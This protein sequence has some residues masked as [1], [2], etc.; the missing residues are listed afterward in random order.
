VRHLISRFFGHLSSRPLSPHEQT[1]VASR[2]GPDLT[3]L[4]FRQPYQDQRHAL[5]VASRV[6]DHL[7]EAALLHDVGKSMSR[8]GAIP[9]SLATVADLLRLPMPA[10]WRSY[11]RHGEIGSEMLQIAGAEPLTVAFA[12]YH[13]GPVPAGVAPDSWWALARAD[14][15]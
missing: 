7:C 14:E 12:R 8:L 13:P 15:S 11:L 2:L 9:R 10:R 6:D 5:T 1:W 3:A 4:F